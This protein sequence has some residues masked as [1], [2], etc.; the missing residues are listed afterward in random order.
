MNRLWIY[1]V[2]TIYPNNAFSMTGRGRKKGRGD[3]AEQPLLSLQTNVPLSLFL[4]RMLDLQS[5]ILK[6]FCTTTLLLPS[7]HG[8]AC[9]TTEQGIWITHFTSKMWLLR[10]FTLFLHYHYFFSFILSGFFICI[11]REEKETRVVRR[12]GTH[13]GSVGLF[14]RESNILEPLS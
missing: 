2:C 8:G 14:R 5:R 6:Q 13:Y 9:S 7:C 10:D 11:N 12:C 1:T 3:K 4:L